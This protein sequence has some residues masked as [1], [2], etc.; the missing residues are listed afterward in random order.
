MRNTSR[1]PQR[2]R[3]SAVSSSLRRSRGRPKKYDDIAIRE[4]LLNAARTIFGEAGYGKASAELIAVKAGVTK[5]TFYR[6]FSDKAAVLEALSRQDLRNFENSL[7]SVKAHLDLE[8]ALREMASGLLALWSEPLPSTIRMIFSEGTR[9]PAL[10]EILRETTE[11]TALRA[12][13]V[14]RRY[15]DDEVDTRLAATTFVDLIYM[16]PQNWLLLRPLET[17]PPLER[18]RHAEIAISL[19]SIAWQTTFRKPMAIPKKLN[20]KN[21]SSS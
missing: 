19:F 4:D 10:A 7:S 20:K 3:K 8:T 16:A 17:Y 18:E 14:L 21:R 5:K 1:T 2:L 11:L 6:Y 13:H 9:F 12:E 15:A